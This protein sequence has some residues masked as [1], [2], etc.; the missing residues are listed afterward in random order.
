MG[1]RT[2]L[3]SHTPAAIAG[4]TLL[5]S[6]ALGITSRKQVEQKLA[7]HAFFDDL[8][9]VPNRFLI[10]ERVDEALRRD[11]SHRFALAFIDLDNFKHINDYYSH[12]AG[13]AL[14][15]KVAE[16][17]TADATRYDM[18]ARISGDEFLLLIEPLADEDAAPGSS[19]TRCST[20]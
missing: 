15:V 20:R 18:L 1:E 5:I 14:L 4:R 19:S 7:Q 16:R 6:A 13:D 17:I 8:T 10:N 9:G 2:W 11:G 12:V 3:T